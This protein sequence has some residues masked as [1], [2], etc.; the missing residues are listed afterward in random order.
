MWSLRG[1]DAD[2]PWSHGEMLVVAAAVLLLKRL[3]FETLWCG[4][5]GADSASAADI[6]SRRRLQ[7]AASG[8]TWPSAACVMK[9]TAGKSRGPPNAAMR[10]ANKKMSRSH[11]F[12][13]SMTVATCRLVES[14]TA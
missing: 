8:N 4:H 11:M 3:H 14:N 1:E 2:V 13:L 10:H 7:C 12:A 5:W 9:T 6:A